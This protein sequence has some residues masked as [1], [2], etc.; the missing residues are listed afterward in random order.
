MYKHTQIGW[1]VI[2][3]LCGALIPLGIIYALAPDPV[4][5]AI[6]PA[7]VVVLLVMLLLFPSLTAEVNEEQIRIKFGP[8]LIY[9]RIDLADIESCE[10]VR[11]KWWYGWGIRLTPHGWMF[12]VSGMEAVQLN[13]KSGKKFRVGTD[14][15]R[16]LVQALTKQLGGPS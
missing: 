13:L 9:R 16:G 8:G 14:D 7:I 15:P 3:P 4:G 2:L 1:F 5:K 10:A 12:N 6:I 11:N